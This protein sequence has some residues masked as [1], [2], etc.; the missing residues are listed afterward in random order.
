MNSKYADYYLVFNK[1]VVDL[2]KQFNFFN[3]LTEKQL[4]QLFS[5]G[6]VY[7]L[8]AGKTLIEQGSLDQ[9]LIILLEGSCHISKLVSERGLRQ[10]KEVIFHT[11]VAPAIVDETSFLSEHPCSNSIITKTPCTLWKLNLKT[12]QSFLNEN[13]NLNE[14]F[15]KS[16]CNLMIQRLCNTESIL[17]TKL[18]NEDTAYLNRNEICL[19]KELRI[20]ICEAIHLDP[21]SHYPDAFSE[22]LVQMLAEY[23]DLTNDWIMVCP[24]SAQA[25]DL[26]AR[27]YIDSTTKVTIISPTFEVFPQCAINQNA[28]INSYFYSDPFKVDVAEFLR[29]TDSAS[30]IIYIANPGNPTGLYHTPKEIAYMAAARPKAI[31]VIDEAY[32]EFGGKSVIESLKLH[33]QQFIITRTMSK[34]F[35]LAGLRIGYIVAHPNCLRPIRRYLI[36][37]CTSHIANVAA[38]IALSNY[39]LIASKIRNIVI[40]RERIVSELSEL[41]YRVESGPTNFVLLFLSE[42]EKLLK[43]FRNHNI[44]VSN[45]SS[46]YL[47]KCLRISIGDEKQNSRLIALVKEFKHLAC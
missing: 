35:G 2:G 17:A 47:G 32:I 46:E 13:L 16:L 23:L 11:V 31:F 26:I 19:D 39:H 42:A 37:Y 7:L 36:P 22:E 44:L 15:N 33:P 45:S 8:S 1:H 28:L 20:K 43:Y 9:A 18:L 25:L 34:A 40:Q 4:R 12:F 24:G 38:S 14:S 10:F 3:S 41:G 5:L 27:T 30:N 21:L 29:N 6:D